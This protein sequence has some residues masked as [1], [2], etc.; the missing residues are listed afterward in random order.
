MENNET[1]TTINKIIDTIEG[2]IPDFLSNPADRNVS[3]GNAAL[4]IIDDKNVVHGRLFGT[5][6]IR[7]RHSFKIAWTKASQAWITNMKTADFEKAVFNNQI[8]EHKFN[9]MR[10][11]FIGWEGGLPLTLNKGVVIYAG[12]SGFRGFK[13][14]EIISKAY[15]LVRSGKEL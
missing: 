12:F 4:C 3:N 6:K 9:I 11:D 7:S 13:D 5:D 1:T 2:L 10:P 8:D 15:S 14:A